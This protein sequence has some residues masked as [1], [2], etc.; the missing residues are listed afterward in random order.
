[1][2]PYHSQCQQDHHTM[3]ALQ[4]KICMNGDKMVQNL[5]LFVIVNAVVAPYYKYVLLRFTHAT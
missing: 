5:H 1:M 3:L 4:Y 2:S